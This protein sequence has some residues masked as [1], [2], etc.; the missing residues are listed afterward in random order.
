MRRLARPPTVQGAGGGPTGP[1]IQRLA[2][3]GVR[4]ATASLP[5]LNRISQAFG[6]GHDMRGVRAQVGGVGAAATQAMGAQAYATRGDR[7]AFAATPGL[8]VAAHEAAHLVQQKG[9]L[10]LPGGVGKV[11]DAHERH[12]DAVADRVV[13]GQSASD[14]LQRYAGPQAKTAPAQAQTH[15]ASAKSGVQMWKAL[16]KAPWMA[17]GAW[18]SNMAGGKV[19]YMKARNLSLNLGGAVGAGKNAPSVAPKSW[20]QLWA[21]KLT[22]MRGPPSYVRMHMLSDRLGGPGN[23]KD[24]LAPGSN[25]MNQRHFN[26]MEKPLINALNGGGDVKSYKITPTYQPLNGGL[27][28]AKG[29]TAWK[30]TLRRINCRATY[31]TVMGGAY[32]TLTSNISETAGISG[33]KNWKGH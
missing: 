13:R 21:W 16:V 7:I 17:T 8:R 11:G 27:K 33:K 26:R 25:G 22:H 31:S 10:S 18:D 32:K 23:V 29:K 4:G 24:N 19:S 12:A 3:A 15:A 20:N 9:G 30:N 28:T 2:D 1:D 14:L 5:H 6:P